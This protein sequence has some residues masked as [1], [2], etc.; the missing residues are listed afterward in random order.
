MKTIK[1]TKACQIIDNGRVC[2]IG[3]FDGVHV[4]HRELFRVAKKRADE[5]SLPFSV[6]TFISENES[7]KK[8]ARLY[9]TD[10]KVALIEKYGADEV[11]IADFEYLREMTPEEFVAGLLI[12]QLNTVCAVTGND[13]RFGKGAAANADDLYQ[14]M[15]ECGREV[16]RVDDVSLFGKKVS[17][18]EIK[19]RLAEGEV[20]IANTML[21]ETYHSTGVVEHGNG[22]GASLG[23]PTVNFKTE[24]HNLL[25]RGVYRTATLAD[26]GLYPSITNV[27]TCPTLGAREEHAETFILDFNSDLYGK[28]VTVYF[29]DFMRDETVFSSVEELK[30]QVI[31]DINRAK[32]EF[33]DN[34]RKLD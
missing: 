26:G 34:G 5:L 7:I 9:S 31:N 18:T 4:G 25:R 22:K 6:F 13:F 12:G 16:I 10:E 30:E 11:I 21:G 27:G 15:N 23:F 14:M 32:K 1:Y 8:G 33:S 2:A 29:L 17:T 19:A 20:G 3:F 24:K 28:A